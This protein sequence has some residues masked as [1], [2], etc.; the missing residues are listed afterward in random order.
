MA[1]LRKRLQ[2][3]APTRP[4]PNSSTR[5]RGGGNAS[6]RRVSSP[7]AWSARN[8]APPQRSAASGGSLSR[9]DRQI[10]INMERWRWMPNNLGSY[11]VTVNIPGVP[12]A[13]DGRRQ[14][15][16]V[17]R[18]VVGKPDTQTPIF[19]NEMQTIVF[20][21]Y[22]TV[23]NSIRMKELLPS[24]RAAVGSS[25]EAASTTPRCSSGTACASAYRHQRGRSVAAR[26]EPHRYPRRQRLPASGPRQRARCTSSSCSRTSMTS[27]CTTRRR[28]PCSPRR[29]APTATAACACK[30][31]ISSRPC[32]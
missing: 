30:I 24:I 2:V 18:V 8:K 9:G 4:R 17:T 5:S 26:L 15:R 29:S 23:P 10:L 32:S 14:A 21:P 28:R 19:S 22:W 7:T 20:G 16:F 3:P 31:P 25:A 27:T 12:A 1:L 6:S 11:Y 13:R